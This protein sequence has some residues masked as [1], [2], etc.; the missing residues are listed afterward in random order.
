MIDPALLPA[1]YDAWVVAQTSSIGEAARRLHKTPSAVSQ[2][3]R[4]IEQHF[5]VSLFEKVG[6]RIRRS[7][8]GEAA[9][10]A[11]TRVFDEAA[12][13]GTLLEELAGSRVTTLRIAAS[14]YLGEALLIPVIRALSAAK[15]PL[16]FEITTTHS[17]EASRLVA[18]S[19]ADAAIVSGDVDASTG[20]QV[21]FAQPFFWVAPRTTRG[22]KRGVRVRLERE[23]LLRLLPG[24]RGRR[25]LDEFLGRSGIRPVSTI[26]MPSVSL[27]LSYAARGLGIGLAPGLAVLGLDRK[28][29]VVEAADVPKLE[30][31]LLLRP[32][33]SRGGAVGKFLDRLSAEALRVSGRL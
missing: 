2:Q 31:Q 23:P 24:S 17:T 15:V 21:L 10:G 8:A 4:R 1:L 3:L 30:V 29:V 14:D 33:L 11:M 28:R 13:L 26:D 7:P 5:G 27:M 22:K 32:G 9:L 25:L 6:R 19:V 16:H 18:E 12:S 20:A